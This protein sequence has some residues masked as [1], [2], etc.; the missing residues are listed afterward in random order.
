MRPADWAWITLF[1]AV[2]G[3]EVVAQSRREWELMSEA[4]DRY[5]KHHPIVTYSAIG[6]VAAHL[7]RLVP[8]PVDPLQVIASRCSMGKR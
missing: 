6:Y 1:A 8:K 2:L 4:C 3:Y 7:A 5:R